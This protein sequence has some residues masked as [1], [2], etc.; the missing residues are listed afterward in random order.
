[1]GR[2]HQ[3]NVDVE[4]FPISVSGAEMFT[5][6]TSRDD[7]QYQIYISMPSSASTSRTLPV[8]YILEANADFVWMSELLKRAS[9][10]PSATNIYPA[11]IVGIGYPD[12][13]VFNQKRRVAEF[14][15]EILTAETNQQHIPNNHRQNSLFEFI[16]KD[17]IPFVNSN[18][19]VDPANQTMFGHSL[20]GFFVLSMLLRRPDLFSSYVSVSPSIWWN[21]EYIF[22]NIASLSEGAFIDKRL[23]IMVGQW[24]QDFAPWQQKLASDPREAHHKPARQMVGFAREFAKK[25]D[26]KTSLD[27]RL[28]FEVLEDEDHA[29]VLPRSISKIF[30][31]LLGTSEN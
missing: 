26:L 5:M 9:N 17:L 10:R 25:I 11:V 23:T 14:T 30:R 2:G 8:I 6:N 27:E 28:H 21:K 24:D 3:T 29:S 1:M 19:N 15:D 4:S 13:D 12:G 7:K 31:I 22:D 18:Y 16:E 20:A